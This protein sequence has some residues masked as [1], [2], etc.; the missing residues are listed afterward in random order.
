ME[1][2]KRYLEKV[3]NWKGKIGKGGEGRK[4]G[5]QVGRNNEKRDGRENEE[6][7]KIREGRKGETD[8]QKRRKKILMWRGSEE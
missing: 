3:C 1:R 8:A 2:K 6:G 5:I 7:R 4:G